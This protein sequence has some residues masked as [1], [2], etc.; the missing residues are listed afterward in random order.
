M[1]GASNGM[2]MRLFSPLSSVR[3]DMSPSL[4]RDDLFCLA[5]PA[6]G[7]LQHII[8]RRMSG[9]LTWT[10]LAHLYDFQITKVLACIA[11]HLHRRYICSY[12]C[13]W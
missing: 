7:R 9:I 5:W 10:A 1:E 3:H 12:S 8:D 4:A 6:V 2:Q 13:L 11:A